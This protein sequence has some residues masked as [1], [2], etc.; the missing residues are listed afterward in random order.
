[1]VFQC[2]GGIG[3]KMKRSRWP[4]IGGPPKCGRYDICSVNNLQMHRN[5]CEPIHKRALCCQSYW[6]KFCESTENTLIFLLYSPKRAKKK[7]KMI[8]PFSIALFILSLLPQWKFRPTAFVMLKSCQIKVALF[9]VAKHMFD[10]NKWFVYTRVC[11]HL[12][13]IVY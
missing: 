2:A 3:F 9:S 6:T 13:V 11:I 4:S 1:M 8:W 10:S 5:R 12:I 7:K